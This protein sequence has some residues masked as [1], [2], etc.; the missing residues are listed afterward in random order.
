MTN[1]S[2][3]KSIEKK[4]NSQTYLQTYNNP[5]IGITFQ[6]PIFWIKKNIETNIINRDG[7]IMSTTVSFID[8][9]KKSVFFLEYHVAP[10]GAEIYKIEQQNILSANKKEV[11]QI[12]ILGTLTNEVF[13]TITTDNKGKALEPPLRT[14]HS[15]LLDKSQT[16]EFDLYFE[17]PITKCEEEIEKFNQVLSTIKFTN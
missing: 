6:Y 2:F 7:S 1:C 13:N 9:I 8:T 3:K 4:G 11:N 10:Y 16:G 14:A 5:S 15:V 12:S 17:T